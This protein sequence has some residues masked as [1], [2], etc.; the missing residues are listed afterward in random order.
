V[1]EIVTSSTST[2]P[3]VKAQPFAGVGEL[4]VSV[5][6]DVAPEPPVTMLAYVLF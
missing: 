2:S 6:T 5:V 3:T 4:N 1:A